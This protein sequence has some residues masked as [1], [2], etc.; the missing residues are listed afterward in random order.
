MDRRWA[1]AR[2]TTLMMS[3]I[4]KKPFEFCTC[5]RLEARLFRFSRNEIQGRFNSS[6]TLNPW[7]YTWTVEI[8]AQQS[9][10]ETEMFSRATV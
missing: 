9:H 3:E 1:A 10:T 8:V 4:F 5:T 2:V 6:S 7:N